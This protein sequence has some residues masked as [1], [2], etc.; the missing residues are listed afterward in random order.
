[1]KS[2]PHILLW[3]GAFPVRFLRNCQDYEL[4]ARR[5][6]TPFDTRCL[7]RAWSRIWQRRARVTVN[8]FTVQ[9]L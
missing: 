9:P 3:N 1:M 8:P 6:A 4:V 7:A 5:E 2:S